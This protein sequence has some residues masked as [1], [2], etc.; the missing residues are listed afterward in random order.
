MKNYKF[1]QDKC[2]VC[3]TT[4]NVRIH[5]IFFG[6]SNRKKSEKYKDCCTVG[7][8]DNHHNFSNQGVH[9]NHDLDLELKQKAQTYFNETYPQLDFI[10]IFGRNYL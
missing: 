6:T 3:G 2:Y 5:H 4:K 8:C 10:K 1:P 7:L 9:F